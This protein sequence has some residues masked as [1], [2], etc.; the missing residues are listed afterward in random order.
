MK[1]DLGA[2][3]VVIRDPHGEVIERKIKASG[4][5]SILDIFLKTSTFNLPSNVGG[6]SKRP[7]SG[8]I[9][10]YRIVQNHKREIEWIDEIKITRPEAEYWKVLIPHS[11]GGENFA[12]LAAIGKPWLAP[13]P[14]VFTQSFVA[15]YVPPWEAQSMKE[16][17]KMAEHLLEYICTKFF[18]Y[19]VHLRKPTADVI[20]GVFEYCP[21]P[22]LK[23]R[24]TDEKLFDRYGLSE[25]EAEHIDSL[26]R[27][28]EPYDRG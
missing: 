12:H 15:F 23:Q 11:G 9:P 20:P 17:E 16:Q 2:N 24:W 8:S 13:P 3:N 10:V 14:S 1:K 25:E 5:R 26:M 21:L 28:M 6:M 7:F 19:L 4:E 22:D 27:T 18:R